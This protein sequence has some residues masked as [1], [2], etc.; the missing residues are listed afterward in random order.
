MKID[1]RPLSFFAD[2]MATCLA[3]GMPP[4]RALELSRS[5]MRSKALGELIRVAR[6]RCGQGM[7]VSEA[8]EPGGKVLPHYFLPVIRAGEA[9]GRLV[10]AF[11]L[12][13]QHCRRIAPSERL[14]RNTWLYPLVC[15]VFGWVIRTGIFLYSA[16]LPLLGI[17]FCSALGPARCSF[18]QSGS[19]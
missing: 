15:V 6:Q 8:L 12:L 7:S 10:E 1:N 2:R 3:A 14:V 4:Q 11:Q 18:W 5:G 17:F 16:S 13:H 19:C 9:G